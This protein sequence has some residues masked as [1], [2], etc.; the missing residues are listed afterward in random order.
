[1]FRRRRLK[2]N[3]KSNKSAAALRAVS[4]VNKEIQKHKKNIL[5]KLKQKAN[6]LLVYLI[7]DIIGSFF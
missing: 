5:F 6:G 3:I 2:K 4:H 1:M 7:N